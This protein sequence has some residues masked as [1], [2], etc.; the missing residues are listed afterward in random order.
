MGNTKKKIIEKLNCIPDDLSEEEII[1][2]LYRMMRLEQSK[3]RCEKEG[4]FTDE[5]VTA[6]F[7]DK[8]SALDRGIEDMEAGRELPL[9]EA[10]EKVTELRNERRN[11]KEEKGSDEIE[12]KRNCENKKKDEAMLELYSLLGQGYK[13]MQEGCESSID[14]VKERIYFNE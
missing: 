12:N 6:H 3:Q 13:A 9:Q 10:M 8:S 2:R 1:E 11:A 7:A 14:E 4:S 5:Q